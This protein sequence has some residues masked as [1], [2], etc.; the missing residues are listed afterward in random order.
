MTVRL[1]PLL[2]PLVFT[3]LAGALLIGLGVWQLQRLAWKETV[4]ARIDSRI[5]AP[6]APLPAEPGW[7]AL[8]P[9]DYDY[10]HV[11]AEGTFLYADEVLVFEGS[12]GGAAANAGPGYLVLTPLRL[13]AGGIVIV[14]RGFVPLD[15]AD[16]ATR[17]AADV[18]GPV[19]VTGLMRPPQSRNLFTPADDPAKGRYFTRD[20]ALVAAHFG[21]ARTAPFTIDADEKNP[22]GGWL[23]GGTTL[24]DIP[25]NHLGYALTW[26]GLA[27]G[28]LGVFA[29]FAWRRLREGGPDGPYATPPAARPVPRS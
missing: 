28:L 20:P 18:E 19:R 22:P 16:P 23:R 29:A 26:F 4:L 27:L 7:A 8:T 3:A 1:R 2:W 21:L 9:D 13:A 11:A 5:H 25:N 17:R 15:R 12:P 6:P 10:R 24:V 14:N